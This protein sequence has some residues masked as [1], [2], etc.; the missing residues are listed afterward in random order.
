MCI[1]CLKQEKKVYF[2]SSIFLRK[3]VFL[4]QFKIRQITFFNFV[5]HAFYLFRA[6]L[7]TVA[8][9][10]GGFVFFLFLII[11]AESLK[12]YSKSRK[13]IK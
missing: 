1:P 13:I 8:T 11:L 10:N 3:F 2:S 4:S 12:N 6:V 7:K 9:V 5:N